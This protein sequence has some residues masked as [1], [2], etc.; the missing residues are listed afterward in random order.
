VFEHELQDWLDQLRT[1]TSFFTLDLAYIEQR[2]AM[3]HAPAEYSS[4]GSYRFVLYPM[5]DRRVLDL[6]LSL[7]V[8]YRRDQQLWEDICRVCWPSL[9]LFP[10][11][12]VHF[13]G[14]R[15]YCRWWQKRRLT[16]GWT[17]EQKRILNSV[18][19]RNRSLPRMVRDDVASLLCISSRG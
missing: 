4:D 5:N 2:L 17:S 14:M 15:K 10:I 13:T 9:R 8:Q 6:M 18:I 16:R 11:N 12:S 19:S 7:P 3:A 1:Y